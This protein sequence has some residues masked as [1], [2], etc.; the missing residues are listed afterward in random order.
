MLVRTVILFCFAIPCSSMYV[1]AC[2]CATC[3][4]IATNK[5]TRLSND[6]NKDYKGQYKQSVVSH[7]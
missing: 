7:D 1:H 2:M 6:H 4:I 5:Q 3:N